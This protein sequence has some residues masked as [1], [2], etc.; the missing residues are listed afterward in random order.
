MW[1]GELFRK[2]RPSGGQKENRDGQTAK[3]G[4]E[5]NL[6]EYE[7]QKEILFIKADLRKLQKA[8]R[9][10]S[11]IEKFYKEK[12][13]QLGAMKQIKNT[14]KTSEKIY[15]RIKRQEKKEIG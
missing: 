3:K 14:Y 4:K 1:T 2:H 7:K 11:K 15:S 10:Y 12:L 13:V 8:K 6:E 5:E 9:D